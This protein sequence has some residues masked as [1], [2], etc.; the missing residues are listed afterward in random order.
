MVIIV[1]IQANKNVRSRSNVA[2]SAQRSSLFSCVSVCFVSTGLCMLSTSLTWAFEG[3]LVSVLSH[4]ARFS[5]ILRLTQITQASVCQPVTASAPASSMSACAKKVSVSLN[6]VCD[7]TDAG[8][9]AN[10]CVRVSAQVRPSSCPPLTSTRQM[11]SLSRMFSG[12]IPRRR[13]TRRSLTST[14][15]VCV[16]AQ[17]SSH[18]TY[19]PAARSHVEIKVFFYSSLKATSYMEP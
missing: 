12:W 18:V 4:L 19:K 6:I 11:T 3:F 5:L 9:P 1:T 8:R 17:R 16:A 2:C 13:S 7:R 15:Y 10:V 14:R